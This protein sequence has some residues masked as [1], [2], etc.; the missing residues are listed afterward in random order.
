MKRKPATTRHPPT[1]RSARAAP[2]ADRLRA[3]DR[4]GVHHGCTR[5]RRGGAS[6]V[7]AGASRCTAA[8]AGPCRG[9]GQVTAAPCACTWCPPGHAN[10]PTPI[11][12]VLTGVSLW[13]R[14]PESFRGNTE[15]GGRG[16]S[17][18]ACSTQP[19]TRLR[20]PAVD[21]TV[22]TDLMWWRG[23]RTAK[24]AR[25]GVIFCLEDQANAF[26]IVRDVGFIG[27][28]TRCRSGL[29]GTTVPVC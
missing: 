29:T 12:A 28:L 26:G 16:P 6:I 25:R 21:R 14:G 22:L 5:A 9:A 18:D 1:P 15:G 13:Q 3:L 7:H 11:K 4:P 10:P 2:G 19:R 27:L 23:S 20:H 17:G 8:G 24:I